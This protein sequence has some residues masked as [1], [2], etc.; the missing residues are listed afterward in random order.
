V[1]LVAAE[2][3]YTNKIYYEL[4]KYEQKYKHKEKPE[5]FEKA[6]GNC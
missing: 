1:D 5:V 3:I 4:Y 2:S 6:Y